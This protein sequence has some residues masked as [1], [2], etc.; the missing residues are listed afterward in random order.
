MAMANE[1]VQIVMND[2]SNAKTKAASLSM[3]QKAGI[4]SFAKKN[5]ITGILYFIDARSKK[6]ISQFSLA[7]S[8]DEIKKVYMAV[9]SKK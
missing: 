9:L 7:Q 8:D 3:L 1:D 4:E 5:T 2:L 6:L